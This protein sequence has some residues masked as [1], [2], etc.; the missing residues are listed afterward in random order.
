MTRNIFMNILFLVFLCIPM[1]LSAFRDKQESKA[2][3]VRY[4]NPIFES[5]DVQKEIVFSEVISYEGETEKLL[6]DVYTPAGQMNDFAINVA[7]FLY[8]IISDQ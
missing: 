1:S 5:V 2:D 3:L 6:L 4:L 7:C 8:E